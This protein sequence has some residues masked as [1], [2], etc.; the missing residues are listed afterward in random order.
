MYCGKCG[1]QVEDDAKFCP[2]CGARIDRQ[3]Q[4]EEI[5]SDIPDSPYHTSGGYQ[6]SSQPPYDGGPTPHVKNYLVE[7][8]L[9]TICCCL[10]F[11]IPGIV[12]AAQ[13]DSKLKGGD[14]DGAIEASE[15]AKK[16]TLISFILGLISNIISIT[17]Y[18]TGAIANT[19]F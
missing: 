3:G 18:S 15:K 13:V 7:S 19:W 17:L 8:I 4:S 1:S 12:F 9:C 2:S 5:A 14:V 6:S 10:P 16:W 11:G